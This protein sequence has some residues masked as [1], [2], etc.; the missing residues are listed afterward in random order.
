MG[1]GVTPMIAEPTDGSLYEVFREIPDP[2]HR[3]DTIF[4]LASVLTLVPAAMLCGARSLAAI[5]Q[6]GRDYNHLAPQLGFGRQA[7]DGTYRTPCTSELPTL[8]AALPARALQAPRPPA[9]AGRPAVGPPARP[10]PANSPPSWPRCRPGC[11]R[12]P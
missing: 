6:W 9:P 12:P 7:R 2:R 11:S 8:L 1:E 10:A 4:P 5:S 3:R